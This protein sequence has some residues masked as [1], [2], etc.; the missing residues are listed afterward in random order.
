MQST[1]INHPLRTKF[2]PS[3][4][5]S[6]IICKGFCVRPGWWLVAEAQL[7]IQNGL[8][9]RMM[10]EISPDKSFGVLSPAFKGNEGLIAMQVFS[11]NY[12]TFYY[13]GLCELFG[14]DYQPLECRFVHHR[15]K[16]QGTV[17]HTAIE[18]DWN[19]MAGKKLV[20]EWIETTNFMDKISKMYPPKVLQEIKFL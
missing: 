8:A 19:S 16:G 1:R 7:A 17:C 20:Q 9:N 6:C 4:P 15:R 10:L 12:C 13:D 11:N 3:E 5:C 2:P 18:K 14:K